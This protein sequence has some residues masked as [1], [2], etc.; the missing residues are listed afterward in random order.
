MFRLGNCCD[1][2]ENLL[3]NRLEPLVR[4]WVELHLLCHAG[5]IRRG[6]QVVEL[7]GV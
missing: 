7:E 5:I 4:V 1:R 6:F 3:R 2:L